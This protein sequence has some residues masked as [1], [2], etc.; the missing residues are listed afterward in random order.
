MQTDTL[1]M[2]IKLFFGKKK[3]IWTTAIVVVLLLG[4]F[5]FGRK[6]GNANIQTDFVKRQDIQKTVL[7]TGQVVSS[8]DLDLSFQSSG[9]VKQI[10]VAEGDKVSAGETLAVLDQSGALAN[11]QSAQAA[12]ASAQANYDKIKAAATPQDIAVSVAA[13]DSASTTLSNAEQSLF[14]ELSVAYNDANTAVLSDTNDLF[15]NPQSANPQFG[16]S[17]TVTTDSQLVSNVNGERTA[18]NSALAAWQTEI[19]ALTPDNV[20]K[21]T[22]DSL[23]NLSLISD[24][25][26]DVIN[27]LTTYTEV[28]TGGSASGLASDATAAV[29][30]KATVDAA[31]TTASHLP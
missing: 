22:A 3:I 29:S 7:T 18:V 19:V 1:M 4:W 13:V 9:V 15:S 6:S 30:A 21:T 14:N 2:K 10:N 27:L 20:D 23:A 28:T 24:Y 25:L 17:G 12:L 31:G 16:I 26:S 11:L 5:F 8:T